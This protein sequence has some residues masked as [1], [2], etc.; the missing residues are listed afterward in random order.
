MSP[1]NLYCFLAQIIRLNFRLSE[2]LQSQTF[3]KEIGQT[4]PKPIKTYFIF[5]LPYFL[6]HLFFGNHIK[7]FYELAKKDTSA[8]WFCSPCFLACKH[9]YGTTHSVWLKKTSLELQSILC[10]NKRCM[11]S[12]CNTSHS[13]HTNS[14]LLCWQRRGH[15][16]PFGFRRSSNRQ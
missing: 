1:E 2:M 16:E 14:L 10:K 12:V 7:A 3:C 4:W 5:S 9:F 13:Y 11:S 15:F 8:G 6:S